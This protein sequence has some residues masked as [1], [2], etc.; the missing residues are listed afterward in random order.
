[1]PNSD[2]IMTGIDTK[3]VELATMKLGFVLYPGCIP[4]GL[5]ATHD[6]L[7]AA[8]QLSGSRFFEVVWVS[9]PALA[10]KEI[11]TG[12]RF[13]KSSPPIRSQASITD[14]ALDALLIPGTWVRAT[15]ELSRCIED[16][17]KL[18]TAL[19][20]VSSDTSL[21]GYCTSVCFIAKTGR[22][23][24]NRATSTW[25]LSDYYRKNFPDVNWEFNQ[26]FVQGETYTCASGVNG[27]LPTAMYLVEK[28]L[29]PDILRK[30]TKVMLLPRPE[31]FQSPF[32]KLD[33]MSANSTEMQKLR[34]IVEETKASEITNTMLSKALYLSERTL[35]RRIQSATGESTKGFAR[36]IK[37]NQASEALIL[38][39]DPVN[40]ISEKLGYPDDRSFRR[41]FKNVTGYSPGKYREHF[42]RVS[43]EDS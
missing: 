2:G 17:E 25:W 23:N 3:H 30:V 28:H 42:K 39:N 20:N 35:A 27:H 9:E 13:A 16:N 21:H 40:T 43:F 18:L 19:K 36:L 4:S 26:A 10:G 34:R 22:L 41:V 8:N 29:G 14:K 24:H 33:V 6:L 7:E 5:F 1:M 15:E 11:A 38:T 31:S 12:T 37:L 32:Q